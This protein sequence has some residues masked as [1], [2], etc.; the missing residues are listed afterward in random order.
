MTR[1]V[2]YM[3]I[4]GL[5]MTIILGFYLVLII[6]TRDA[7]WVATIEPYIPLPAP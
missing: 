5:P 3:L 1:T 6:A 2:K 7:A 4:L